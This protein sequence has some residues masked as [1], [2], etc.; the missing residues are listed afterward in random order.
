[1]GVSRAGVNAQL[2]MGTD[3]ETI[4]GHQATGG[5]VAHHKAC[6]LRSSG[7]FTHP[8]GPTNATMPV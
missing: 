2:L 7:R 6:R 8:S 4:G 5:T 1:M 3:P